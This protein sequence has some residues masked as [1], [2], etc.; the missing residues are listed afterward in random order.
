MKN[1]LVA[2]LLLAG[3]SAAQNQDT[4]PGNSQQKG[5]QREFCV[6]MHQVANLQP[7]SLRNFSSKN[8]YLGELQLNKDATNSEVSVPAI[9]Q[10]FTHGQWTDVQVAWW[11]QDERVSRAFALAVFL[12]TPDQ[13]LP[14]QPLEASI[15]DFS[16]LINRFEPKERGL[17]KEEFNF[18]SS[19][20]ADIAGM[21]AQGVKRDKSGDQSLAQVYDLIAS[22]KQGESL[23]CSVSN[24]DDQSLPVAEVR[25]RY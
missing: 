16:S 7:L 25:H 1:L 6:R 14:N 13:P 21:L 4:P 11:K 2:I 23:S 18:V 24:S 22:E 15:P 3:V 10:L 5:W 19:H 17:R 20:C 12:C 9:F 8:A